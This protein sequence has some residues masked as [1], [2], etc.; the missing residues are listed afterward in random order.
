MRGQP[1][2]YDELKKIVSLSLTPTALTGL[3]EFSACLNISRSELVERIGQGLLT[4]SELT[5]KTE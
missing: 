4:I 3:N 5:T 1:E 2:T